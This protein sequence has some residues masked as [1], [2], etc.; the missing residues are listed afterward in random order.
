MRAR[1]QPQIRLVAP[2]N[3][4][5]A[6][7]PPR[8]RPVGDL[9]VVEAGRGQFPPGQL[10]LVGGHVRVGR[11]D[12]AARQPALH[13]RARLDGQAIE[14]DVGDGRLGRGQRQH[15]RQRPRPIG[16]ALSRQAIDEVEV[17]VI[18]AGGAGQAHGL[19]GGG[20]VVGAPQQGQLARQRALHAE[21]EP[22]DAQGAVGGQRAGRDCARVGLHRDLRVG[23][24]G[25]RFASGGQNVAQLL[26]R[27]QGRRA[28]AEEDGA[29]G[30]ARVARGRGQRAHLANLRRQR[31][32]VGRLQ[33][34]EGGVGV[35]VAI[36]TP[37][38]AEWDVQ[39]ERVG[40]HTGG[41]MPD[42]A[43][44]AK[45]TMHFVIIP[46]AWAGNSV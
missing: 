4:V 11:E 39:V 44:R 9:V 12:R 19:D 26:R 20:E 15:G 42:F 14:A 18:E 31:G 5:V 38:A 25:E 43:A 6:A 17:E 1:A 33:V 23:Q 22:V 24:H 29:H 37:L 34:A 46:F 10:I 13:R 28:A 45:K 7:L 2:V 30:R 32:D 35:E 8:P 21:A 36:A 27:Q 40:D 41:I 3:D 16:H